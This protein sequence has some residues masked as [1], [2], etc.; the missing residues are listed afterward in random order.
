VRTA[1]YLSD[2]YN[3]EMILTAL[4]AGLGVVLMCGALSVM[5]VV[6]RLGFVGQ[7]VSH[8]AFGGIGVAALFAA[9]GVI[10]GGGLAQLAI[11][12]AFCLAA[13]LGMA[14][15]SDRRTVPVDTAIGLFLV[16][17]MALGAVLVQ[18]SRVIAERSGGGGSV[19]S[20]ESILFG[21]ILA[22]GPQ[23]VWIAWTIAIAVLLSAWLV[24]RPMLFWALDEDTARAF[25][26]RCGL[27]RVVLMV[28]L[29]LAVVVAM[30]LAGVV[31]ATALLVL[32][33]ATALKLSSR[34][35]PV[36]M[37]SMGVGVLG[38]VGGLV[39]SIE[40]DWQPGPCVVLVLT[41]FFA[42]AAVGGRAMHRSPAARAPALTTNI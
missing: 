24:R 37:L 26:V 6:K 18:H 35:W 15:V 34:F 38:L 25:G 17:S 14:A 28:L 7:G 1:E 11:V 23:D 29:S 20:W 36:A 39:L 19:Q 21:S 32:P 12:V 8:S 30:K 5:V 13:A 33:G 22:A 9:L 4:A 2:P 27:M 16:G 10:D 31:L 3:R 41:A 42:L 40:T